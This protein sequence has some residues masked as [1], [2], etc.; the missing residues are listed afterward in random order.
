VKHVVRVL[1]LLA[2][3]GTLAAAQSMG[4]G[5]SGTTWAV[6]P[7]LESYRFRA[8]DRVG[9]QG[10]SLLS[11]PMAGRVTLHPRFSAE[12]SG[13]WASG[14]VSEP[15]GRSRTLSGLTDATVQVQGT[16]VEDR[17][18]LVLVAAAPTGVATHDSAQAVVAGVMA[19]D[20]LP[21]RVMT[22]GAGGGLGAQL[23]V[24]QRMGRTGIGFST[25]VRR[26]GDFEPVAADPFVYRPGL[27]TSARVAVDHD[28]MGGGKLS[29]TAGVQAFGDD[30]VDGRNLFRSGARVTAIG[31][32]GV[33]MAGGG[34]AALYG[35]VLHRSNGSFLDATQPASPAQDLLLAGGVLRRP[36]GRGIVSPRADMRLFRSA[37][38]VG[39]G[40][41]AS[42]GLGYERRGQ[43]TVLSPVLTAR[44]GQ[45]TVREGAQSGLIGLDLGLSVRFLKGGR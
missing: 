1:G 37:D 20:L 36:V 12:L 22:W 29:F 17:V 10:I 24:T 33:P 4:V 7:A 30:Q 25:G 27:E 31:T 14:T 8:A 21:F 23:L 41:L 9:I 32:L 3:W 42:V 13:A 34:S 11:V 18:S 6:A 45:V 19:A 15:G 35:G 2:S 39:Q 26:A 38:G 16:L 5:G 43:T 40:Y 28:L 44:I